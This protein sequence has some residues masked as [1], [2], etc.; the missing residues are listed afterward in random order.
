MMMG[1]PRMITTD[2]GKE[3][4]NSLNHKFMKKLNILATAYHPQVKWYQMV[5]IVK[6]VYNNNYS[7]TV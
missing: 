6:T 4:N 5:T 3:F 1:L 2:Q 7:L